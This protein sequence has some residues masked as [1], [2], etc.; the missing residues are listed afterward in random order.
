MTWKRFWLVIGSVGLALAATGQAPPAGK[1][2]EDKKDEKKWDVANPPYPMPIEARIDTDEG[3]WMSLDVSPDGSEIVFDLLGDLYTLPIAGGEAR[4]LTSGVPWDM[5]PRFSPDGKRIAFTSDR[6]GGDNIWIM[7]RDGSSPTQVSKESFRLTNSPA[8][9]PDGDFLAARKHFTGTRSL[10]SGEIWLYHRA[11]GDGVQM[12]K[13]QNEQK[14][15]G[16]PAFSPD[17]RYLYYSQDITPGRIYQYNKDPNDEIYAIQRLDRK[18]GRTDRFVSGAGGSIRPTPSHDGKWLAF[19]RRQRLKT[20]LFVKDLASGHERAVWNGLERDMQET[21]AIHGV[22]P[23]IAWTPDDRAI[24]AWAGG[25]FRR[26]D[27]ATGAAQGIPFHVADTRKMAEAVRYPID[28]APARFPVRM[29]RWVEV[30]PRGDQVAYE[31]LGRIWVR[32]L[33]QGTPR[34]LTSQ[35]D[36]FELYPSW[37]R[38]GRWLAFTTWDDQKAGT[39]R[40]A[41]A[42]GGVEKI[43]TIEPGHYR[44]PVFSPDGATVVYRKDAGGF[45]VTPDWSLDPGLYSVPAA[46]GKPSFVT[47]DGVAPQF[48]AANDR[49]YF[50][51]FDGGDD[52][53]E[54]KRVFASVR[55]DGGDLQEHVGSADA[56]EFRISPDEKWI[57]F[58]ERFNAYLAP[59]VRT[60]GKVDLGPK[61]TAL[62]VARV[63]RDAGEYLRWSGDS[64]SLQWSLGPDLFSRGLTDSF[65]FLAGA[66]EKLPEPAAKGLDIG[67]EAVAD[68]PKGTVALVGGRVVTMKGG[69]VLENGT[70]VVEGNRIAAVGP[71]GQIAVP[72]GARVVDVKGKTVL[73]GIVD[74]H[75]HG[76]MGNDGIVPQQNWDTDAT[77]GFGVT[78]VHDPS[79]DS[80]EIFAA[81][82]MARAGLLRAPRIYSTGT[83]LYGAA[84]DFKAEIDSLDEALTHLRRMKA[85]GAISVKSYNQPRREQRQQVL[86]AA[87]ETRMLVVPEG[88]SLFQ[89]NMTQVVDGHTG[90]EHSIP[91]ANIYK[92]V[93]QLWPADGVGYT[94]TLIVG[95]GGLWGENYW[96]QHTDVWENER[97]TKFVPPA[98][99]DPRSRRRILAPEDDF[100]HINNAKVAKQLLDAGT[101]VQVGAHGQREGLGAHWEMWMLVQGG[102]TPHEA[103][104]CATANGAAYLG[105]DKD[106]GSL[107]PGKLADIAVIDGNPLADIRQTEKVRYTMVNGRLYD[108]ATMEEVGS[109]TKRRKYWWQE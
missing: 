10:G 26:I 15:L 98:I 30:S 6:A 83:I 67:F 22:Y 80:E 70:V 32:Y 73:P 11:G 88:G 100:N 46:G 5:Q 1:P 12:T 21:W 40:V 31:S 65:L 96:Y 24:V 3:T 92:D 74:V 75:W 77:L 64:R 9:A 28:V 53:E 66:P 57:A 35:T 87:R 81:S 108:S 42:R 95:Y 82:E 109:E 61:S 55:L 29:L 18:T 84:G 89:H 60:G 91:V 56:T 97:L 41:P 23:G 79:H 20:V 38:D 4:A 101:S 103:L 90:I 36:H 94:P 72:A 85:L 86:A 2:A 17:G 47:R 45:L 62:P 37:S 99:L 48:G 69:E 43:L 71:T 58:R 93:L 13:R 107:E 78:T 7:N 49:V 54:A 51:R 8:W 25:K 68:A 104:R 105:M 19:V 59:F 34:R 16:E 52:K 33:P 106:L 50:L 44:E 102:M 63:S 14:D 76:P 27:V 39:V